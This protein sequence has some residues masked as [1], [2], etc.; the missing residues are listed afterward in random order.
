MAV[1]VSHDAFGRWCLM[2]ERVEDPAPCQWCGEHPGRFRY[3]SKSDGYGASVEWGSHTFC[4][5]DCYRSHHG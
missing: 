3:G 4:C 1:Q 5:I 2:R